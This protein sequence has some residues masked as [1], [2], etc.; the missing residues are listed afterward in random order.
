MQTRAPLWLKLAALI[1]AL[2]A[3]GHTAGMPWTPSH[4]CAMRCPASPSASGRHQAGGMAMRKT[5]P[6]ASVVPKSTMR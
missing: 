2:Y 3:A 6:A 1:A 5:E 4:D